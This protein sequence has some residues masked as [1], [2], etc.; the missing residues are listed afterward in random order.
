MSMA[1]QNCHL[2][3]H[4]EVIWFSRGR[5]FACLFELRKEEINFYMNGHS[6][7]K[8]FLSDKMCKVNLHI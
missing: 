3:F 8:E 2:I 4:A 5:V 7:L 6:P 1:V